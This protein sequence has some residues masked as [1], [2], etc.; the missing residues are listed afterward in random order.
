VLAIQTVTEDTPAIRQRWEG[1]ASRARP[2]TIEVCSPNAAGRGELEAFIQDGFQRKHGAAVRSFMPVLIGLRDAA[3]ALVGA[4]GYRPA[5]RERLY[6]EQY[7][8]EPVEALVTRRFPAAPV[9]R[10]DVAEIGNFACRDCATAMGMVEVLAEFL[11]DQRNRWTVFTATRTVRGIMRHL[12]I[13]L[14]ELG[15]ADKSRVVVAGDDWGSYYSTDPR[16]MLGYVPSWRGA[17]DLTWSI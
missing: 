11:L 3:G 2:W 17:R 5:A 7:L 8:G 4:A 9:A 13:G 12:G 14:S 10:A 6:L 1:A 15:R 16:V